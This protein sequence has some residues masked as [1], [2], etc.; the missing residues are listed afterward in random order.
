M[1]K[2]RV[3]MPSRKKVH[4]GLQTAEDVLLQT[5]THIQTAILR[6][7]VIMYSVLVELTASRVILPGLQSV[8]VGFEQALNRSAALK[9]KT[10][11]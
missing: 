7:A 8:I 6:A 5:L 1:Q 4:P 9:Q 2:F 10:H 3:S 11:L